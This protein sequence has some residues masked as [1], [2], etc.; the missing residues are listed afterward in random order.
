MTRKMTRVKKRK[1]ETRNNRKEVRT[2][3]LKA[4]IDSIVFIVVMAYLVIKVNE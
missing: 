1:M 2:I 3:S 4:W